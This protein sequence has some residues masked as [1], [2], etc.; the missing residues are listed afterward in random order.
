M[1]KF[2][3]LAESVER[4]NA[5]FDKYRFECLKFAGLLREEFA[6]YLECPI[7]SVKFVRIHEGRPFK[8]VPLKEAYKL[9]SDNFYHIGIGVTI[10][11]EHNKPNNTTMYYMLLLKIVGNEFVVG[12]HNGKTFKIPKDMPEK[13]EEFFNYFFEEIKWYFDE[14]PEVMGD[15]ERSDTV[16]YMQLL[17]TD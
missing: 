5:E 14:F 11:K 10:Y 6:K 12:L 8:I 1:T 17:T 16:N 9:E 15:N 2:E 4:Y 13:L 3:E 7:D